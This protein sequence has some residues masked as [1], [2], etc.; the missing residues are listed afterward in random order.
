MTELS[1]NR[2]AIEDGSF[3]PISMS[4]GYLDGFNAIR[5][6]WGRSNSYWHG[7]RMAQLDS[8]TTT[9]KHSG[10]VRLINNVAGTRKYSS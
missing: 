8:A 1:A 3:D 7:W 6:R 5:P 2:W 4:E 10:S 9:R